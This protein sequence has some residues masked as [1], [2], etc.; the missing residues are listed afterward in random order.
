M[1]LS[2]AEVTNGSKRGIVKTRFGSRNAAPWVRMWVI[3]YE[4]STCAGEVDY[5][6]ILD[7][8]LTKS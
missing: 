3:D 8:W 7:Y 2:Q 4:L 6:D 5:G 1:V